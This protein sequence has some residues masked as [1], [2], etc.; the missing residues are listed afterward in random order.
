M[1]VE[2]STPGSCEK[3][4]RGW[5]ERS[6]H[7]ENHHTTQHAA[8]GHALGLWFL[9]LA[10]ARGA[11]VELTQALLSNLQLVLRLIHTASRLLHGCRGLLR[12]RRLGTEVGSLL[13]GSALPLL[14]LLL[15]LLN[16]RCCGRQLLLSRLY[17]F[18]C[19]RQLCLQLL[20]ASP[21]FL[22]LSSQMLNLLPTFGGV[23]L[24]VVELLQSCVRLRS[25]LIELLLLGPQTL[26]L[27]LQI[28]LG[29]CQ[30]LERLLE[31]CL[32]FLHVLEALH[33]LLQLLETFHLGLSGILLAPALL[34]K[35]FLVMVYACLLCGLLYLPQLLVFLDALPLSFQLL[36]L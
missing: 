20:D 21:L 34:R 6:H 25:L 3:V 24:G 17:V 14:E 9:A 23:R 18:L 33:P 35:R 7:Q 2:T 31:L 29:I 16:L 10:L 11:S 8:R 5:R 19:L 30:C 26:P 12:L 13:I 36:P 4:R 1:F 32:G 28:L 27:V 22:G 15:A